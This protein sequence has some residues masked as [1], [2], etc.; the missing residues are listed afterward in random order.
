MLMHTRVFGRYD[1][2][3]EK[4]MEGSNYTEINLIDNYAKTAR[5]DFLVTTEDGTPVDS[6]L[7]DFKIYNY[8]EFY[9]ALS[10]YTDASGKTFLSAGLGDMVAWA[11][12]DGLYGY[13]K[14]SFG[15]DSEVTIV[16]TDGHDNDSRD[17][18]IVPPPET[19][20]I[21]EVTE[22]QRRAND[23]RFA[24][25][26]LVRKTYMATFAKDDGTPAGRFLAKS[27]GN[28][29][30]IRKF[31][32]DHPD[33][34]ALDLLASL[35]D[36]DMIDVTREILDDSYL[37]EG[38]ILCPRVED[39]FLT[40]YKGFFKGVLTE[41]EQKELSDPTGLVKWV[42]DNIKVSGDTKAWRIA[43]SPAGV[44]KAREA[45]VRSRDV[46]FVS[47]ART[48]GIDARRDPVTGKIQYNA[49]GWRDVDFESASEAVAPTGNLVLEYTPTAIL[50]NPGYYSQFT[51]S[52]IENGR[53]RL[54]T[55]DEGQVDMGGGVSWENV[56]KKGTPLD[57]G[58][59]ILVS[60][61]RL[62]D[63]SVP[64]TL[65]HFSIKEGETTPL[66]LTI[67]TQG[68]KLSVIGE[69]SAETR[70]QTDPESDPVS[71]L[72]TTGRGFYVIAFFTPRQEPSV[73]AV[74]DLIAARE[75]LEKWGRPIMLLTSE[76]GLGW[77]KE[78]SDRLP[79]NVC[80]GIA[81]K[82]MMEGA[83]P[84]VMIADTFNRVYFKTEG[85][86][87]GLGDQILGALAKL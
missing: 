11:S 31:L 21:P 36:K 80:F 2:P 9:P 18:M 29:D 34:R 20:N 13:S 12:K 10:K 81:P 59:Y 77:V 57:V 32:A 51:I 17:M 1:G 65:R 37:S 24:Q 19:A 5:V 46:F 49:G 75:G 55:F 16:L 73:H 48:L 22:D 44:F 74:N 79:S 6:A 84:R 47:L 86:T 64:V 45:D 26:D 71:V 60:G 54:L 28:Q 82:E 41:E 53:T 58:D 3:E 33:Q 76:E 25:E 66:E 40:P 78:Y 61:N 83:M 14:V 35:S 50:P 23:V 67:A 38:S 63:G 72:S 52:K 85:Y 68:D 27:A 4:V 62:S 56:F 7:V 69:F 43:M 42:K 87:I 39:E 15:K 8:A 70:Y 30:V